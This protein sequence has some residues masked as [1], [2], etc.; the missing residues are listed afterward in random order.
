MDLA[1]F[2]RD[3]KPAFEAMGLSISNA[4]VAQTQNGAGLAITKV[5]YTATVEGVSMKQ[6]QYIITVGEK[7][8]VVTVTEVTADA[9]LVTNVFNTLAAAK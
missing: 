2:N 7:T 3:M 6:T 1:A 9:A 5:A 4:S 8:Y